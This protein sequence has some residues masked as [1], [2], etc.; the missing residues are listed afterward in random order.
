LI[1]VR[2]YVHQRT[3]LR[4]ESECVDHVD[5]R[6]IDVDPTRELDDERDDE[7]ATDDDYERDNDYRRESEEEYGHD[8][9]P[10][11]GA[12]SNQGSGDM[13][14]SF[15]AT[16]SFVNRLKSGTYGIVWVVRRE[17]DGELFVLKQIPLANAPEL[18]SNAAWNEIEIMERIEHP[19]LIR[20][21]EHFVQD[22]MLHIVMDFARGGDLAAKLQQRMMHGR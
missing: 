8:P 13:A 7:Y 12:R 6:D 16:Y 17:V 18:S 15:R 10:P 20:F 22:G 3:M 9:M 14:A 5:R 4:Q 11:Q 19:N 2:E 21:R 1:C